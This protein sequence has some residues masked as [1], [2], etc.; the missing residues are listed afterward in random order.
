MKVTVVDCAFN[1]L[2]GLGAHSLDARG[3]GALNLDARGIDALTLALKQGRGG[4]IKILIVANNINQS[5][6]NNALH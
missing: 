5:R 6:S 2:G 1:R 3:L 4:C